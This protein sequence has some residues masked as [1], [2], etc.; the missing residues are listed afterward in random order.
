M[1]KTLR[2]IALCLALVLSASAASAISRVQT[3]SAVVGAGSTAVITLDNPTASHDH[4]VLWIAAFQSSPGSTYTCGDGTNTYVTDAQFESPDNGNVAICRAKD[5]TG[6]A[7]HAITVTA[8]HA[9]A[10]FF[11]VAREYSGIDLTSPLD[12]TPMGGGAHSSGMSINAGGI[13]T[14]T[15]G[16]V[17]G[18]TYYL[19]TGTSTA[20]A[21]WDLVAKDDVQFSAIDRITGGAGTYDPGWTISSGASWAATGAAYKASAGG[22]GGSARNQTLT[23]AGP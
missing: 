10:G 22:G 3:K 18:M 21:G 1:T 19:T 12:G 9:Q 23:G 11:L 6:L 4:V 8:T 16:L 5:I 17:V 2:I 13:V 14:S 7:T 20:N 15:A